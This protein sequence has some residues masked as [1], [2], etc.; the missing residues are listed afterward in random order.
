MEAQGTPKS[1]GG[2]RKG[3]HA[4]QRITVRVPMKKKIDDASS[5]V[6]RKKKTPGHP[7]S[8]SGDVP[9]RASMETLLNMLEEPK[10]APVESDQRSHRSGRLSQRS[11]MSR[12]RR[13]RSGASSVDN[14]SVGSMSLTECLSAFKLNKQKKQQQRRSNKRPASSEEKDGSFESLEDMPSLVSYGQDSMFSSMQSFNSSVDSAFTISSTDLSLI[15][16]TTRISINSVATKNTVNTA[17]PVPTHEGLRIPTMITNSITDTTTTTAAT[18]TNE[19]K[20]NEDAEATPVPETNVPIQIMRIRKREC[21]QRG[22]HR[23]LLKSSAKEY[24]PDV[25]PLRESR[26]RTESTPIVQSGRAGRSRTDDGDTTGNDGTGINTESS[27]TRSSHSQDS[28]DS[29]SALLAR[30]REHRTVE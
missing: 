26:W 3:H 20:V 13:L 7:V 30:H 29:L 10:A 18:T 24:T 2:A 1:S 14:R 25:I 5:R 17:S 15:S 28:T 6:L 27:H 16:E 19:S 4:Q 8:V 9:S 12:N 22:S 23:S 11:G 21:S